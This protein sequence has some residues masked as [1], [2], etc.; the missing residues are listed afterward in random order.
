MY[1]YTVYVVHVVYVVSTPPFDQ[2]I[3]LNDPRPPVFLER[4]E[5]IACWYIVFRCSFHWGEVLI[6]LAVP[7]GVVNGGGLMG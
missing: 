1:S 7:K 5:L 2:P 3:Y 4:C 6:H